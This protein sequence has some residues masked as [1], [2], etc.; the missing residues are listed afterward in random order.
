PKAVACPILHAVR[1]TVQNSTRTV[2]QSD[3]TR[4]GAPTCTLS[5]DDPDGYAAAFPDPHID[6][7]ITGAGAFSAR[8][9]R[10]KLKDLEVY[11]QDEILPRFSYFLLPPKQMFLSFPI[12]AH[13]LVSDGCAL[14]NGDMV[15]H[16]RGEST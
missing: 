13:S 6:F 16:G 11:L 10:L 15:L 2:R 14:R 5:F 7:T 8:L 12:G 1:P 9:T 3:G 4:P